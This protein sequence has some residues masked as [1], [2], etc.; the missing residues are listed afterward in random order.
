MSAETAKRPQ[1]ITTSKDNLAVSAVTKPDGAQSL[2]ASQQIRD[3]KGSGAP[4]ENT[5][6]AKDESVSKLLPQTLS[7]DLMLGS[8]SAL[9]QARKRKQPEEDEN[10][11]GIQTEGQESGETDSEDESG[12]GQ[13]TS[14]Q[15]TS[16]L[17]GEEDEVEIKHRDPNLGSKS[18]ALMAGEYSVTRSQNISF[19]VPASL[20]TIACCM[21]CI[22]SSKHGFDFDSILSPSYSGVFLMNVR[23]QS[24]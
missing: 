12:S 3:G 17:V 24:N 21:M 16:N 20:M 15:D 19:V 1:P 4:L 13:P 23:R 10:E 11:F 18:Q 5:L 6:Q 9:R 22:K 2:N 7:N 14:T 8:E